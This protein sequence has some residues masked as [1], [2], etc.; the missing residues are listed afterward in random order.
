MAV[1]ENPRPP[2]HS[3]LVRCNLT[4]VPLGAAQAISIS[5]HLLYRDQL[6]LS[7]LGHME[8]GIH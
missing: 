7:A 1:H 2:N 3:L 5:M 6:I 8:L 4:H